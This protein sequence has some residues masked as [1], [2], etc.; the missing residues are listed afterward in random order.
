MPV[1]VRLP[2]RPSTRQYQEKICSAVVASGR[3][4]E[5]SCTDPESPPGADMAPRSSHRISEPA[6]RSRMV[7]EMRTSPELAR[8]VGHRHFGSRDRG[9]GRIGYGTIEP[10][11]VTLARKKQ[12]APSSATANRTQKIFTFVSLFHPR[13]R[14][15]PALRR[16]PD[17]FRR[18]LP[19]EGGG[20]Q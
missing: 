17:P 20:A 14:S 1:S 18:T 13:T 7:A 11:R 9:P 8:K 19:Q 15:P 2:M 3:F 12:R 6:T 5:R 16:H 10:A 4:T